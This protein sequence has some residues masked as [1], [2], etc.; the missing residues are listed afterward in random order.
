MT[1]LVKGRVAVYLKEM[2][3][4]L[5]VVKLYVATTSE[6]HKSVGVDEKDC[7]NISM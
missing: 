6:N 3:S 4:K 5:Y 1:A 2:R 7:V